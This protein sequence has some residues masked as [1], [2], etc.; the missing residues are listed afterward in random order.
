M[1][2]HNVPINGNR[3]AAKSA[4]SSVSQKRELIMRVLHH[5]LMVVLASVV[6]CSLVG[7]SVKQTGVETQ[8]SFFIKTEPSLKLVYD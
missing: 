3:A 2:A 4:L 6:L 8:Y 1:Y 7:V 5:T